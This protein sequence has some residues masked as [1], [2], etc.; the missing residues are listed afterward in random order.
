MKHVQYIFYW[1][2]SCI[3]GQWKACSLWRGEK[4]K[5]KKPPQCSFVN[6]I[7][8]ISTKIRRNCPNYGWW[9]NKIWP[10]LMEV[11]SRKL[12]VASSSS[13]WNNGSV[14]SQVPSSS[15]ICH[16]LKSL[17]DSTAEEH[18]KITW[19]HHFLRNPPPKYDETQESTWKQANQVLPKYLHCLWFTQIFCQ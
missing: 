3:A 16:F 18:W 4:K 5:G 12:H 19:N 1:S 10:Y 11:R 14:L 13:L 17:L 8:P 9:S 6:Q 15:H 2:N 7:E